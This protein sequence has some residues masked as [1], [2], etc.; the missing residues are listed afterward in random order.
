MA[1]AIDAVSGPSLRSIRPSLGTDLRTPTAGSSSDLVDRVFGDRY[2]GMAFN[3]RRECRGIDRQAAAP[4]DRA[5][6]FGARLSGTSLTRRSR[7][8]PK[9]PTAFRAIGHVSFGEPLTICNGHHGNELAC[10]AVSS[11][12]LRQSLRAGFVLRATL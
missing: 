5:S 3:A 1:R 4:S 12:V 10:I 8:T 7:Q 11:S 6:P 2:V 9:P